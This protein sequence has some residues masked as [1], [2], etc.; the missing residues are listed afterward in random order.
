MATDVW[1]VSRILFNRDQVSGGIVCY[2]VFVLVARLLF[3]KLLLLIIS[4]G[5]GS[6]GWSVK[7]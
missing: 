5:G 1:G 4:N 2:E 6:C 7:E 3:V